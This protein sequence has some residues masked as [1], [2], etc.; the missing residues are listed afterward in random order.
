MSITFLTENVE[1]PKQ[2]RKRSTSQWIKETA[3][4]YGKTIGSIAYI[5]CDDKTII[6]INRQYLKHDY[7]TDVIT[8][9]YSENDKLSGDIFISIDTVKT[10]AEKFKTD[11]HE[12]LHRVMIHGILHLCGYEDKTQAGKKNMREKEDELL[13]VLSAYVCHESFNRV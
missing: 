8:F 7:Y 6:D 11:Y 3:A 12:E 1:L 10:N 13:T 9:D 5:F 2:F 4:K